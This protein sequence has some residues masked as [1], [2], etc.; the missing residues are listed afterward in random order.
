MMI[1]ILMLGQA[2]LTA[3]VWF[4]LKAR[5]DKKNEELKNIKEKHNVLRKEVGVD[6][7]KLYDNFD[8]T[9]QYLNEFKYKHNL[10][11]EDLKSVS[12]SV[13]KIENVINNKNKKA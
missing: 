1:E 12:K 3:I 11:V 7:D 2:G 6:I 9:K 4:S 13:N 10:L 8:L 5:Q